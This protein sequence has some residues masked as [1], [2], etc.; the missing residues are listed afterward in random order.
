MSLA[1]EVRDSARCLREVSAGVAASLRIAAKRPRASS[2]VLA[3]FHEAEALSLTVDA[4]LEKAAPMLPLLA[5]EKPVVGQ[6]QH[7]GVETANVRNGFDS[8]GHILATLLR[9]AAYAGAY[10]LLHTSR[11]VWGLDCEVSC[12]WMF[13]SLLT[14]KKMLTCV[15]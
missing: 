14:K 11:R 2:N 4:I 5:R 10:P 3:T 1:R 7:S 15:F 6:A 9:N 8:L 13:A 12:F